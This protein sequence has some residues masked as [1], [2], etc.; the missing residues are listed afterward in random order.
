MYLTDSLE[1]CDCLSWIINNFNMFCKEGF[2]VTFHK[3]N[4]GLTELSFCMSIP[5]IIWSE[6]RDSK[7]P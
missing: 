7:T 2:E 6:P 1:A 5:N 3:S 4:S